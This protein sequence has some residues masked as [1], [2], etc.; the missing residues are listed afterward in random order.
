MKPQAHLEAKLASLDG[1]D[2]STRTATN[3]NHVVLLCT[4]VNLVAC[5]SSLMSVCKAQERIL[6]AGNGAGGEA[7]NVALGSGL[8]HSSLNSRKHS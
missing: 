3:D 7:L 6:T 8:K 1:S 5:Q 2:I 4:I